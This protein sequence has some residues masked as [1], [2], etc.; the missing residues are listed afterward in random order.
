[1]RARCWARHLAE[2]GASQNY[3]KTRVSVSKPKKAANHGLPTT[4]IFRAYSVR[5]ELRHRHFGWGTQF[6]RQWVRDP[7]LFG[8]CRKG[9]IG[10]D[11][12]C[13]DHS[14]PECIFAQFRGDAILLRLRTDGCPWRI[15]IVASFERN[16]TMLHWWKPLNGIFGSR[17]VSWGNSFRMQP[18]RLCQP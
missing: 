18:W 10:R 4:G 13:G 6:P 16:V 8:H 17:S 2:A 5:A 9:W 12:L 1:M 3:R 11:P 14:L 7:R 15:D